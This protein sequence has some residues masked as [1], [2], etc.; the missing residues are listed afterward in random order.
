[1]IGKKSLNLY[2]T[3]TLSTMTLYKT[4]TLPIILYDSQTKH[5]S[6]AQDTTKMIL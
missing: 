5:V 4:V 3:I 1:M 6:L 2:L